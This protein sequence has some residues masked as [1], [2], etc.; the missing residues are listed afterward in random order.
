MLRERLKAAES[1]FD[2]EM[3]RVLLSEDI[4]NLRLV[5][6]AVI[7]HLNGHGLAPIGYQLQGLLA[8]VLN[9]GQVQVIPRNY[10]AKI[11]QVAKAFT[12][13]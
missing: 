8:H 5:V 13:S 2:A 6:V 9:L 11:D 4:L 12:Y 1:S 10:E 3:R 7:N